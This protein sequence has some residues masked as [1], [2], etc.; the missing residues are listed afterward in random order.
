MPCRLATAVGGTALSGSALAGEV[1][2]ACDGLGVE[3]V[4]LAPCGSAPPVATVLVTAATGE[5]AVVAGVVG[6]GIVVAPLDADDLEH[7]LDDVTA[8]L[9]DGHLLP[10]AVALAA[11]AR[12]LGIPVL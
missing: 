12:H 9:V 6:G 10:A 5:R 2:A 4:D 3:L 1:R 7:L 8:A 11:A